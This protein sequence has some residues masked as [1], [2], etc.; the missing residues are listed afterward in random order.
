MQKK[1]KM[2]NK[3]DPEED[4]ISSNKPLRGIVKIWAADEFNINKRKISFKGNMTSGDNT[5][6]LHIV[7]IHTEHKKTTL[8]LQHMM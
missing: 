1:R 6:L 3:N 7:H 8:P 2:F 5:T 4:F